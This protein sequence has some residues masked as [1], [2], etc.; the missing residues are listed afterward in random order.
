MAKQE[1]MRFD[2]VTAAA[3]LDELHRLGIQV[4]ADG[5]LLRYR[6]RS[7]VTPELVSGLRANKSEI[8]VILNAGLVYSEESD[9]LS[10]DSAP[11]DTCLAHDEDTRSEAPSAPAS[12]GNYPL[13]SPNEVSRRIKAATWGPIS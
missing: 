4:V 9:G 6:P 1:Q 8:I 5:Q 12:N 11:G 2:P 13:P 10:D 7:A 3:L